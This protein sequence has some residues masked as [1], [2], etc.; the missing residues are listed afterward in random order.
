MLEI[1][2]RFP[3]GALED[4]MALRLLRLGVGAAFLVGAVCAWKFW[5]MNVFIALILGFIGIVIILA[6]L[7]IE[8]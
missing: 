8:P 1:G 3:V 7:D 6:A 2:V 5:A 4:T